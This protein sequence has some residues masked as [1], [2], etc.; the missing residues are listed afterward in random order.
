MKNAQGMGLLTWQPRISSG[1]VDRSASTKRDL[2]SDHGFSANT[3]LGS[4][5][6][7]RRWPFRL[8]I[9]KKKKKK[10]LVIVQFREGSGLYATLMTNVHVYG[11]DVDLFK[12]VFWGKMPQAANPWH[13][14]HDCVIDLIQETRLIEKIDIHR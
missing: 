10:S 1:P 4:A 3:F 13:A 11:C 2:R 12:K 9:E 5:G 7:D 14:Y 6:G 8:Y